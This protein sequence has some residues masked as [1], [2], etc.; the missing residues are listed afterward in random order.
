M[1][2]VAPSRRHQDQ[3]GE[4][5]VQPIEQSGGIAAQCAEICDQNAATT[6]DQQVDGSVGGRG[7]PDCVLRTAC[8]AQSREQAR[9]RGEDYDIEDMAGEP[10][11]GLQRSEVGILPRAVH[12]SL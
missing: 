3:F 9:V 5:R 6:A 12:G 1:L 10:G 11:T 7:V 2:F 8:L 4:L